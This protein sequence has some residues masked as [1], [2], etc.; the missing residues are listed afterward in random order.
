MKSS[1][2]PLV[3][4]LVM[5]AAGLSQLHPAHAGCGFAPPTLKPNAWNPSTQAPDMLRFAYYRPGEEQGRLLLTSYDGGWHHDAPIVGM[6]RFTLVTPGPNGTPVV[7][8]DGYAQ[9]HSDGTEIQ[10]S[11]MHAPITSNFC[12]GVWKQVASNT[13]QLNHFPLAWDS[14]GL[15]P[16]NAI[17]LTEKVRLKDANHLTGTFTLK[18]YPWT[19]TD[20]LDVAGAPVATVTGTLTAVRVTVDST[21]PGAP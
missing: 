8:D 13:Y 12:L 11:G 16:A 15:N 18:V 7:V 9:W 17:Q 4:A 14:N 3:A 1:I 10:N 6:W 21:V 2:R 5:G 20:S 19:T